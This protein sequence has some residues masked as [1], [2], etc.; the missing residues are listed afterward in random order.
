MNS[1]MP[2]LG[3]ANYGDRCTC[4]SCW[5]ELL[6][7]ALHRSELDWNAPIARAIRR[8]RAQLLR[9]RSQEIINR[10]ALLGRM[11]NV[12]GSCSNYRGPENPYRISRKLISRA[13]RRPANSGAINNFGADEP[14][15][16]YTIAEASERDYV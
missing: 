16:A 3:N 2:V 5:R 13:R 15:A 4:G 12:H 9:R 14:S 10:A 1:P 8:R 11:W 6:L 7:E